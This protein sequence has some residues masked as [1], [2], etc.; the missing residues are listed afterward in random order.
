MAREAGLPGFPRAPGTENDDSPQIL[1]AVAVLHPESRGHV[2]IASKSPLD[3]PVISPNYLSHQKDVETFLSAAEHV[4]K[5]M[6][7][8][9]LGEW[10]G[11]ELVPG[12]PASKLEGETYWRGACASM[13]H[14][15]GTCRLGNVVDENCKVST[16]LKSG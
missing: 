4:R 6:S 1:A 8:S 12:P 3:L 10:V 11:P 14:P 2:T 9:A 13:W 5:W 7:A 15:V 16:A